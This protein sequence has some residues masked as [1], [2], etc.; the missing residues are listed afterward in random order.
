MNLEDLVT[1]V[2]FDLYGGDG[3]CFRIR[4]DGQLITLEAAEDPDDGYRSCLA[5]LKTVTGDGC[6]FPEVP[7]TQVTGRWYTNVDEWVKNEIVELVDADGHVWLSVGTSNSDD[8]YPGYVFTFTPKP[9]PG[10]NADELEALK[11]AMEVTA[12]P[13]PTVYELYRC[14]AGHEQFGS[15]ET[16]ATSAHDGKQVRS[17]PVCYTCQIESL[18][19]LYPTTR[20]TP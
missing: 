4:K 18:G 6:V 5:E 14:P 20:V 11:G 7:V 8:Y 10:L 19:T 9:D 16:I 1:D 3:G 15:G 17:G 2:P 12:E 13:V